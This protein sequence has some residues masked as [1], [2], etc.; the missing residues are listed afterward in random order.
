MFNSYFQK[1]IVAFKLTLIFLLAGLMGAGTVS[2][3]SVTGNV[4][5][6]NRFY[7]EGDYTQAFKQYQ[8][9]LQVEPESDIINF[10]LGTALYKTGDY[11][12]AIPH[13]E[14]ALLSENDELRQQVH[15]NLA[16]ALYYFGLSQEEG[17]IDLAIDSLEKALG[18]EKEVLSVSPDDP[19]ARFN[20][21]VIERE[22]ERLKQEREKQS[23][24]RSCPRPSQD[25]QDSQNQQN[26]NQNQNQ[27]QSQKNQLQPPETNQ[28]QQK[29][30]PAGREQEQN[31]GQK[32]DQEPEQNAPSQAQNKQESSQNQQQQRP[33]Q[34]KPGEMTKDE[35]EQLLQKYQQTEEPGGILYLNPEQ[36][37]DSPVS[38]D[39]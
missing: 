26:Q 21:E 29:Q 35:A 9:A 33:A 7:A 36:G 2:A 11:V 15:Y 25:D 13:L 27:N 38:K 37:S 17:N 24:N 22:L 20:R 32:P 18:H 12:T 19:D 31:Q 8:E 10:N 1:V 16:N 3:A 39:W 14:K 4:K 6:G 30:P 23:Q 28:E 34:A 5:S